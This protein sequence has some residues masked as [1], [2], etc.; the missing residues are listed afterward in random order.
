MN[1]TVAVLDTGFWTV[2]GREAVGGDAGIMRAVAIEA[3][4]KDV[5]LSLAA[6]LNLGRLLMGDDQTEGGR[7]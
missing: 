7:S 2:D 5:D 3:R 4:A 6:R 1:H